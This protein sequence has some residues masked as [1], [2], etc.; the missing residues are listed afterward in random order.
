MYMYMPIVCAY[1]SILMSGCHRPEKCWEYYML[2]CASGPQVLTFSTKA[3]KS[4]VRLILYE[5]IID[6]KAID[7]MIMGAILKFN[8]Q[9]VRHNICID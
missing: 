1:N 7:V 2:C 9:F 5:I 6:K 4:T 8:F 3:P